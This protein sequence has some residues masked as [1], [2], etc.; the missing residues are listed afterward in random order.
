MEAIFDEEMIR[1]E[2]RRLDVITG[3]HGADLPIK[4]GKAQSY[5]GRFSYPS[6][7]NPFCFRRL[8]NLS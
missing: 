1:A 3:L 4:F 7:D 5:L 6:C 8:Y 2:L